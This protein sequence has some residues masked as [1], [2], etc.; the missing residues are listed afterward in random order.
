MYT[1]SY[2][3]GHVHTFTCGHTP[4]TVYIHISISILMDTYNFLDVLLEKESSAQSPLFDVL[5]GLGTSKVTSL[6]RPC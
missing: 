5:Q 1:H 3:Q 2:F 6:L 4:I